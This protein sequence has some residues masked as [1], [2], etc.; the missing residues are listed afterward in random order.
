MSTA[1]GALDA[2]FTGWEDLDPRRAARLARLGIRGV[3]DLLFH[4][5]LRYE[6]WSRILPLGRA[7]PG[8]SALVAGV[9]ELA[10][11]V[12]GRRRRLLC[13]ISDGTGRLTLQFFHFYPNQRKRLQAG[14]RLLCYGEVRSGP[15]GLQMTHP[16]WRVFA[17][18]RPI[19]G[20]KEL[21]PVYPSTEGLDQASL[22]RL[23][24]RALEEAM[25]GRAGVEL[26]PRRLREELGLPKLIEALRLLHAPPST[27]SATDLIARRHPAVRRLILEELL[28]H[29]L[30]LLRLRDHRQLAKSAPKLQGTGAL[31]EAWLARLPFRL[32]SAQRRVMR[33][34]AKDMGQARPMLRLVQGDVGCGKTVIAAL[35]ALT[36]VEAGW[37]VAFMAPTELLA[38]QHYRTFQRWLA[39]LGVETAW[40]TGR[41]AASSRREHIKRLANGEIR[42]VMGTHAL[43][44]DQVV[45]HRLGLAIVDEQHRFGVHQRLALKNKSGVEE[46]QPHQLIMTATPIPRTL[47]MTAYADLDVS[48]IDE[49]PPGRKPIITVAISDARRGQV[50]ERIRH[51]CAEGRQAYWVCTRVEESEACQAEAAEAT[52]Q[53]LRESLPELRVGLVHG[54]M[55][56]V[57]KEAVMA[58]FEAGELQLL[59][60]TTVIEVGVDVPNASLMII[61]N[62]ERFGLA[63]LH[64][65]RGRIGRGATASSCVLMYHGPLSQTAQARLAILRYTQDGFRIAQR[66]LELRGP[67]ELLGTRQ[68]GELHYRIA[69]LR[70]DTDL[71][72]DVRRWAAILLRGCPDQVDALI[73]RWVGE[74]ERYARV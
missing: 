65:L 24:R 50:I 11:V 17:P 15:L 39:P 59:V 46:I 47:A 52:A 28:A 55:K 26:L 37:Q 62:A 7:R 71:L 44:Q 74:G 54:R 49:L 19:S 69:D 13:R 45:F 72:P 12:G 22:R 33:E 20:E 3:D 67:G 25:A 64:Q 51:A 10:E 66:D 43:F 14:V 6:D 34:V 27:A 63:Q 35:A 40:L 16:Q 1:A 4:L 29:R 21:T 57:E 53:R 18:G 48:V 56:G 31:L 2:S 60:A 32:T 41:L 36:T 73:T 30:S 38:E 42:V 68:T 23:T 61:E 5:P 9:V 58:G 70:R 8:Q